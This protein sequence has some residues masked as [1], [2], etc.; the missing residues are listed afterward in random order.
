MKK[1]TPVL[2]VDAIEPVLPLWT[3]LG[4]EKTAEVPEGDRLGFVILTSGSVELM[5]QSRASVEHDEPRILQSAIGASGVFIEVAS[6]DEVTAKFPAGT[7]VIVDRRAT[8][9]GST[10]AIVR[11]AAGNIIVFAQF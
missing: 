10:E 11:D 4:F 1:L 3:A 6:L 2:I 5:Y 8:P 9:Y 7:D